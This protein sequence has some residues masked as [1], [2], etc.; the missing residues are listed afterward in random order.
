MFQAVRDE[1]TSPVAM[2]SALPIA[3]DTAVVNAMTVDV[4]D[5]FQVSAFEGRVA[6]SAWDGFESRVCRNTARMLDL[7]DEAGVTA[8][9]FVLGWV[10]ERFPLLVRQIAS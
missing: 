6:R 5:Y 3:D 2:A 8:T 1:T 4:E 7:F 9:F 10:A